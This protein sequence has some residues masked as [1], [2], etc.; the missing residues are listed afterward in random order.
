MSPLFV[1][2]NLNM[3]GDMISIK[4]QVVN[5][6]YLIKT[7]HNESNFRQRLPVNLKMLAFI[8]SIFLLTKLLHGDIVNWFWMF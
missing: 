3:A 4:N 2:T 8:L 5:R 6:D 1:I 7:M